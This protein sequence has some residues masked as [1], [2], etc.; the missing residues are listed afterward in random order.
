MILKNI[1]QIDLLISLMVFKIWQ[2]VGN[3]KLSHLKSRL[4]DFGLEFFGQAGKKSS[5]NCFPEFLTL[6]F[7]SINFS[8]M[9]FYILRFVCTYIF[10]LLL[11]LIFR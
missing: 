3:E 7:V 8:S 10:V 5:I 2:L 6:I 11:P 4:V 1:L 9:K